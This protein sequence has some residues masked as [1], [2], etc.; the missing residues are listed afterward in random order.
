MWGLRMLRTHKVKGFTLIE[1][2][3]VTVMLGMVGLTIVSTFA[4]GLKIFNRMENYT[5]AK[6]DVLLCMEKMEKDLRSTFPVKGIDFIGEPRKMTFPAMLRTPLGKGSIGE[7]VGSVSYF[8]TDRLQEKGLV[9]EEKKYAL[10]V[11]KTSTERGDA[12]VLTTVE[13]IEFQYFSYDPDADTYNW[14]DA[15][16][17]S[18]A[19]E[20]R[21]A[22]GKAGKVAL[23]LG[24]RPEVLPLGVK[25]R[26]RYKE[27][28]KILTLSRMV[29]IKTAVSLNAA[30]KRD[31]LEKLHSRETESES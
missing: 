23:P 24:N 4:G 27:G 18:E 29:F 5:A 6:A 1:L 19:K 12:A 31:M 17:K 30:K 13:D 7:A 28:R 14:V 26:I 9:R 25:I 8:L 15:W 16:N 22:E 20:T 2:M 10:A 11:N 3:L 21:T